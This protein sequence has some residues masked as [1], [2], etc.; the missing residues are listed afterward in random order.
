MRSRSSLRDHFE[1]TVS[2]LA[3]GGDGVAHIEL[4]GERRAVFIPHSA[5]GD[6]VQVEVD[7]S[8]RP[9]RG[10]IL[11]VA[12]AGP[13]RVAPSCA[14][15]ERCGGCDWMHLSLEA[16][17]RTHA[18]H[19]RAALPAPWRDHPLETHRAADAV[20]YR[21]RAR[22]HVRAS[23]RGRATVGMHEA[24]SHDPVAVDVCAVLL[25]ALEAARAAL[26]AIFEG[27]VGRGDAQLALGER[28]RPVIDVRWEG[29]LPP[30][31]FAR[32]ERAVED[33]T[34]GGAQVRVGEV[35]RP[36]RI[37]DPT[38][39]M[40]GA[41]GAPLRLAPGGFGQAHEAMN[42]ALARHVAAVVRGWQ[43]DRAVELYAGAGNLTVLLAREARELASVEASR[44]GVDAARAN[45]AA[46][47]LTH[48][49]LVEADAGTYTWPKNTR[50]VVLDPPRTGARAVAERLSASRV[51]HVVYVSCDP[52]TL[53]RDLSLLAEA[54]APASAVPVATFEMFP[55]TSHVETVVALT[56]RGEEARP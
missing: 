51:P 36:A 23:S 25:P 24:R 17:A 26:P 34:L 54:Y 40:T 22:V 41:D 39:W 9:A 53:G 33:G 3:P 46:R 14:W 48:V 30:P 37:G 31:V 10:R 44:D 5:P 28:G 8:R 20:A 21:S 1:A 4:G 2:S 55:Q 29:E 7:A 19:V 6:R 15:S 49:R 11:S 16:Q 13:D 18:E 45:L 38:P 35:A 50:L 12:T 56:H 42:A 52:Q 47:G 32:L 43:V 27:S